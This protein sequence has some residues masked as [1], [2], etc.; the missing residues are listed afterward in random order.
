LPELHAKPGWKTRGANF[1]ARTDVHLRAGLKCVDC[2]PA[3]SSA[4]DARIAGREEHQ[5]GKGDDPGGCVRDDLDDTCVSCAGCH[6]TGRMGA[7]I[8]KHRWLPPL[9]LEK[10][11]CQTCHIPQRPVKAALV[12]AGDVFNPGTKIPTKGKHLW[13][14]YGPDGKYW[15]HYGDLEMMGYDDKSTA[16]FHPQLAR[17]KGKIYPINRVHS[18]WPAI[19]LEGLAALMQPKMGDIYTMWTSHQADAT[20]YPEL[21]KITDD[22]GDDVPEV[23]RP[24]EIDALIQ[25]VTDMLNQTNYP[26]DGKQ[27]VW[28]M[29]DRVY[30]SG[31][32]CRTLEKHPWEASP[33]AN[34]H[35]YHHDVYPAKAALGANGCTDCHRRDSEFFFARNVKY[36]FDENAQPVTEPQYLHMG[37]SLPEVTVGVWRE[38]TLKPI[39]YG[40]IVALCLG[41]FAMV[42]GGTLRWT[43]DPRP[44]P[45]AL[46][47]SK[48]T[49]FVRMSEETPSR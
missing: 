40:L 4:T 18:A 44:V 34:V 20:K 14:F 3:G 9:H 15:N 29:D 13:T 42:G 10:I 22:N 33:Y 19:Q 23:N 41:I 32:K 7:P 25:S 46:R 28:V 47:T 38:G 35:K 31:T 1:R 45:T 27:V 6:N 36:L 5:F 12:Q 11:A 16:P 37:L 21:S 2:H 26:M 43:F 17:Y 30:T 39:T 8:A 24:E 48:N 49:R